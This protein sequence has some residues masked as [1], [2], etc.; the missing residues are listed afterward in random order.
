M[1]SGILAAFFQVPKLIPLIEVSLQSVP[2]G[3][4]FLALIQ[5]SSQL[6]RKPDFFLGCLLLQMKFSNDRCITAKMLSSWF[7]IPVRHIRKSEETALRH[8]KYS[9]HI[10]RFRHQLW[11]SKWNV[12]VN[13]LILPLNSKEWLQN[14]MLMYPVEPSYLSSNP[15][16]MDPYDPQAFVC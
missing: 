9:V 10:S 8:L 11:I 16:C 5:V 3:I 1:M 2:V 13:K 4:V 12:F 7:K 14:I 15:K 6:K